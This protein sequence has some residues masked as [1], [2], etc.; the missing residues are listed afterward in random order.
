[1]IVRALA[2]AIVFVASVHRPLAAHDAIAT[3]GPFINGLLHPAVE[4]AHLLILLGLG[5]WIGRQDTDA[6]RTGTLTLALALAISLAVPF[7]TVAPLLLPASAVIAGTFAAV[8]WRTGRGPI[9]GFVGAG[10]FVLGI[11]SRGDDWFLSIGIWVGAMLIA[12]N[13]INLAMRAEAP[14][15]R[16][17]VRI[18]GA[19]VTAI[20]LMLLTLQLR[21]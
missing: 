19:W 20:A 10:T 14:W 8:A 13:V 4:P 9:A 16:I 15:Q 3:A 18:A 2:L 12:L 21:G 5:L 6:L 17:G 7:A 1:M 11:D